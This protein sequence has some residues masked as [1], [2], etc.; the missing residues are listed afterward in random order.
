MREEDT[1][2]DLSSLFAAE[3]RALEAKPFVDD[4]MGKVRRRSLVR[5][6]V[7]L[8]V[9]GAGAVVAA[10]QLPGLLGDWTMLDN[11]VVNTISSAQQQAGL[12][13]STDPLWLGIAAVVGL[14]VAAVTA[15]ERT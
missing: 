11:T 12:L 13:A 1:F 6:G 2:Q 9:G 7:L 15:L 10:L 4:V 8:A 3:D 5:R 14:C